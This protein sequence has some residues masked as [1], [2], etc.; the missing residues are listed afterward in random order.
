M[1]GRKATRFSRVSRAPKMKSKAAVRRAQV[2]RDLEGS[3]A[4]GIVVAVLVHNRRGK[5]PEQTLRVIDRMATKSYSK[6]K[7]KGVDGKKVSIQNG[8]VHAGLLKIAKHLM[9]ARMRSRGYLKSGLRE[10][11]R[12]FR[13]A[14]T[15]DSPSKFRNP[16]GAAR[17]AELAQSLPYAWAEDFAEGILTVAP[18]AFAKT[19]AKAVAY[20]KSLMLDNLRKSALE[21]GLSVT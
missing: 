4:M 2:A 14:P 21:A 16:P 9:G 19:E 15:G 5:V 11:R 12:V 17:A 1:R 10:A 8:E 20:V 6:R 18:D 13:V 3:R 7:K